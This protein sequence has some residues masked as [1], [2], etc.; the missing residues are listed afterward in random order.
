[1]KSCFF[2][3]PPP[4]DAFPSGKCT[5]SLLSEG[6]SA[7]QDFCPLWLHPHLLLRF[8]RCLFLFFRSFL[9]HPWFRWL[10][11]SAVSPCHVC[12]SLSTSPALHSPPGTLILIQGV[13]V[14]LRLK[15]KA[16][17]VMLCKL[18]SSFLSDFFHPDSLVSATPPRNI[19]SLLSYRLSPQ[20]LD[21][22][23]P[24]PPWND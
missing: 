10:R 18:P 2:V 7:R 24:K 5:G 11:V 1:L 14:S 12:P 19:F 6:H 17:L 9:P 20:P 8:H 4:R 16:F 23:L 3:P 15:P 13:N 21:T 22:F